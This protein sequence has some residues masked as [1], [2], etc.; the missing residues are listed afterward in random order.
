MP[1]LF[2]G[3]GIWIAVILIAIYSGRHEPTAHGQFIIAQYAIVV[4]FFAACACWTIGILV[5]F[6]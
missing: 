3:L 1:V 4:G 6:F 2:T 5:W